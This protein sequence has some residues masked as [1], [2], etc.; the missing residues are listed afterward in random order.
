MSDSPSEAAQALVGRARQALMFGDLATVFALAEQAWSMA[1]APASVRAWTSLTAGMAAWNAHQP[2]RGVQWAERAVALAREASD[3]DLR[4]Q[5][6]GLRGACLVL[7]GRVTEA[8][9]SLREAVAML[10]EG[11]AIA[12]RRTV[13][14]AVLVGY[15]QLGL[16]R[17]ELEAARQAVGCLAPGDPPAGVIR[18][19]ANFANAA[20]ERWRDLAPVD[21][22]AAGR[23]LDQVLAQQPRLAGLVGTDARAGVILNSVFAGLLL[24]AGRL[25]EARAAAAAALEGGAALQASD[26]YWQEALALWVVRARCAHELGD[27]GEA[28]TALQRAHALLDSHRDARPWPWLL[29]RLADLAALEGDVAG[30]MRWASQHHAQVLCNE[31]AAVDAQVAQLAV[32]VNQHVLTREMLQ[33]QEL[34]RRDSLTG[35]LNRRAIEEE[36]AALAGQRV[37]LGLLDID[38]FKR[39]NDTHGHPAGDAVLRAMARLLGTTLR[40]ADRVGRH[41][42]EE[43]VLLL[44]GVDEAGAESYARR[45]EQRAREHTCEVPAGRLAVT[46]SGGFVATRPG[47]SFEAAAA[48]AD[49]LLYRAKAQGRDRILLDIAPAAAAPGPDDGSSSAVEAH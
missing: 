35:L 24:A 23:L 19:W 16:S 31:Q 40:Q 28:A 45:L 32:G 44:V 47:E 14:T 2:A 5:A 46:L 6:I 39:V 18:T 3:D 30:A 25:A 15:R 49:V 21:P 29:R 7:E 36:F 34:A 42:G 38:H 9:A 4:V 22:E 37:T 48:R 41:G 43:F 33:W 27:A 17:L 10:H 26:D 8:V 13:Y 11:M 1:D 20:E 12:A